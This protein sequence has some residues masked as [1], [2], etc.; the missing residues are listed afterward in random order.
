MAYMDDQDE[1][2]FGHASAHFVQEVRDRVSLSQLIGS[3]I[4]LTRAGREF[5][6]CCPFHNEKTPSFYVNDDKQFF[7][8]FGCGAHGDVFGFTMRYENLSFYEALKLLSEQ[9][10]L[11]L[12]KFTPTH[13]AGKAGGKGGDGAGDKT[14]AQLDEREQREQTRKILYGICEDACK[15]FEEQLFAPAHRDVL[16]YVERRGLSLETLRNFRIGFAPMND[17]ELKS[18]LFSRGYSPSHCVRAGLFK[19]SQKNQREEGR[20]GDDD[21][22]EPGKPEDIYGFFRDRVMFPVCDDRG[23]IIAFGG[24][25]LPDSMRPPQ[26]RNFTPPKYLNSPETPLF[27]KGKNLYAVQHARIAAKDEP[28]LVVE[29]YM[30]VIACQQAGFRGAVAPLGTALTEDQILKLWRMSPQESKTPILCFDGDRAGYRAAERAAERVIPLLKSY[31]SLKFA[32]LPGGEDPDTFIRAHGADGF[33]S[34][35]KRAVPL[36]DFLW[37]DLTSGKDFTT[38]ES[39]AGLAQQCEDLVA[40]IH[41]R[42]VQ[43]HYRAALRARTHALFEKLSPKMAQAGGAKNTSGFT[44]SYAPYRAGGGGSGGASGGTG[45]WAGGARSKF[46]GTKFNGS[47]YGGGYGSGYGGFRSSVQTAPIKLPRVA[48]APLDKTIPPILICMIVHFPMLYKH[49]HEDCHKLSCG[50]EDFCAFVETVIEILEKFDGELDQAEQVLEHLNKANAADYYHHLMARPEIKNHLDFLIR[51]RPVYQEGGHQGGFQ[52]EGL[53]GAY[54]AWKNL[55]R[56]WHAGQMHHDAL[57]IGKML[58]APTQDQE[59]MASLEQRFLALKLAQYED[60]DIMGQNG[61]E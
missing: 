58:A 26:S 25:T 11:S 49:V 43:F 50:A 7:H 9:A 13:A 17:S 1:S 47:A 31:H 52:H 15:W 23:R 41:D 34:L 3:K 48:A 24:R 21:Q 46:G 44:G 5:K 37:F 55:M 30:D 8:C 40:R 19:L 35:I 39:K 33:R 29:G 16:S 12:P 59:A 60:Q 27:H 10:G 14:G 61:A 32:F 57:K 6:G 51:N 56:Q 18:Y 45:G 42:N 22:A 36:V 54:D 38:P 4:R 28:L 53:E 20:E 2:A